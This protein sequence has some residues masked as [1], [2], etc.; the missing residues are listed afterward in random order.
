MLTSHRTDDR[1]CVKVLLDPLPL[2]LISEVLADGGYDSH[3][4]YQ[5]LEKKNIKPLVPPPAKA[6]VSTSEQ[7]T[8]RD[9]TVQ[10]IKDK[11]YWLGIIKMTSAAE[12]KLRI[13]S[14]G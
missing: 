4:L 3:Q 2:S 12:I 1:T 7:L 14:I 11:G 8:L 9:K 10:Y 5:D 13:P 6:V